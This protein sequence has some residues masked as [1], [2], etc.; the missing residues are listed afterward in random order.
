MGSEFVSGQGVESRACV[1]GSSP[2]IPLSYLV[3]SSAGLHSR[4][5]SYST[6][7]LR[8]VENVAFCRATAYSLQ[9]KITFSLSNFHQHFYVNQMFIK[10]FC[11]NGADGKYG[12]GQIWGSSHFCEGFLYE[13]P[14]I[15]YGAGQIRVSPVLKCLLPSITSSRPVC[16]LP[17][18]PAHPSS[19]RAFVLSH[20]YVL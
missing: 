7:L 6:R 2:R 17:G 18:S 12:M 16:E 19:R 14:T 20:E 3:T 11:N 10:N 15:K 8:G 4:Y 5:I 9:K 1:W 13:A